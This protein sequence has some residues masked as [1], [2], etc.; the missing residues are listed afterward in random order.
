MTLEFE[1]KRSCVWLELRFTVGRQ[2]H[3]VEQGGIKEARIEL[4]GFYS[5]THM[6]GEARKSDLLPQLATHLEVFGNLV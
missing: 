4:T 6:T 3:F 5:V 1:Q 2:H